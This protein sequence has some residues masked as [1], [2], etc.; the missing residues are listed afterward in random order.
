M[1]PSCQSEFMAPRFL[2][3]L[4]MHAYA[5]ILAFTSISVLGKMSRQST[6]IHDQ[7]REYSA[8]R[9]FNLVMDGRH[10]QGVLK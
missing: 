3:V 1:V 4:S 5:N 2:V 8:A 6:R 10:R 9:V 7:D